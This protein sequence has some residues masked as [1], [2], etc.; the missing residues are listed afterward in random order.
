MSRRLFQAASRS[1]ATDSETGSQRLPLDRR[2]IVAFAAV[3]G[4]VALVSVTSIAQ[5]RSTPSK[6]HANGPLRAIFYLTAP[7]HAGTAS[8]GRPT[9][10]G[11]MGVQAHLAALKWARADAAIVPWATPG[12]AADRRIATVLSAITKTQAHVRVAALIDRPD[13]TELSQLRSLALTRATARA[14]LRIGSRP[15]VFVAP[16]DRSL[17]SCLR[18]RRWRAAGRAFWLAQATFAG[19]GRCREAADA[20]FRDDPNL[21]TTRTSSA[22]LIRPGVWPSGVSTPS[23]A[24]SGDEWQRSV[25]QM[26]GSGSPLQLVDSLNDWAR[27]SAIEPS[28]A[29]PSA[30][31]FGSYLDQLHAQQPGV[32]T[33]ATAPEIGVIT[34]SDV[35]AHEASLATTISAGSSAAAWRIEFGTTTEYGQTTAPISVP[36]AS[37]HRPVAVVLPALTA[38]TTY[39]VRIVVTSSVGTVASSDA[40]FTTLADVHAY[41]V[42]AAGDIACDPASDSFNDGAGT[43][44]ACHQRGVSDA[45]LAGGYDAVLP[46]G[47]VQYE[48]GAASAFQGSYQPSW[49]RFKAITHPTVGNHEYGSPNATPYFQYFGAAAGAPGMGY[50]SYEVGSWH[51]IVIN[52]NCTQ[53]G[54][55]ATGTPQELW[56]RADLAA[57]PA[58]CTLAYWHHPRFSSGQAGDAGSMDAIWTDLYNADAELVLSGHDHDYERFAPQNPEGGSDDARGIRQFVAGTGGKNHMTFKTIKPNSEL[59]DTSSFGFLELTLNPDSYAWKFVS[60]PPGGL[61]D[62]GTGSC[63]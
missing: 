52:S 5:S 42:A 61:S 51:L 11:P 43:T 47:D 10:A 48:S 4:L 6:A 27:G 36:A 29:W 30:S 38:A 3:L 14:Y 46:L 55:C 28:S 9:P 13:G 31:G 22:F 54:G 20:W 15:A 40:A 50:Y 39:H 16:A 21:R 37:S 58:R 34:I 60:D 2:Q 57:H 32:A 41:R 49:G 8:S 12:S 56:L 18:A 44:T 25:E 7:V 17:R 53:V 19:Y 35:T 62:S 1:L 59:H 26:D 24:R 63:H 45:I 33:L 23:V